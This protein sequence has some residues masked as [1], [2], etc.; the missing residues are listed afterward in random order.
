[1]EA[2]V[3]LCRPSNVGGGGGGGHYGVL[4]RS[5]RSGSQKGWNHKL[6]SNPSSVSLP[7][8]CSQRILL[9]KCRSHL[10]LESTFWGCEHMSLLVHERGV[11]KETWAC[12]SSSS[13]SSSSLQSTISSSSPSS[14][15]SSS[16]SSSTSSSTSSTSTSSLFSSL[17][18]RTMKG[19]RNRTVMAVNGRMTTGRRRNGR[20]MAAA[21]AVSTGLTTVRCGRKRKLREGFGN[22]E[23]CLQGQFFLLMSL[24][25][26][27]GTRKHLHPSRGDLQVCAASRAK[28]TGVQRSKARRKHLFGA[29][30]EDSKAKEE[31]KPQLTNLQRKIKKKM[32]LEGL[33]PRRALKLITSIRNVVT[34]RL[35][36][37]YETLDR[38]AAWD[39][40]FPLSHTK[41]AITILR[42]EEDWE[43]VLQVSE[44]MVAKGYGK[45]LNTYLLMLMAYDKLSRVEDAEK[46]FETIREENPKNVSRMIWCTMLSIFLRRGRYDKMEKLWEL[47]MTRS[48]AGKLPAYAVG[49]PLAHLQETKNVKFWVRGSVFC[50]PDEVVLN[51]VVEGFVRAG[52]LK[53]AERVL[54]IWGQEGFEIRRGRRILKEAKDRRLERYE[55]KQLRKQGGNKDADS[56]GADGAADQGD[57]SPAGVD[58]KIEARKRALE[59]VKMVERLPNTKT[60]FYNA[61]NAWAEEPGQFSLSTIRRAI[62]ILRSER[63]WRKLVQ[64]IRWLM[65]TGRKMPSNSYN[66]L[67]LSYAKLGRVDDVGRLS[68]KMKT[69]GPARIGSSGVPKEEHDGADN[70]EAQ[71]GATVSDLEKA[72]VQTP[73]G[74]SLFVEKDSEGETKKGEAPMMQEL[75]SAETGG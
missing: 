56:E 44:W 48:V 24:T 9:Q 12:S 6:P 55:V 66:L 40:D 22:T 42:S 38:W 11:K 3:S 67:M 5:D 35:E 69:M 49:G 1:M 52:D 65:D 53:K 45:T 63:R 26:R 64:I 23:E 70:G 51:L 25:C 34:N 74:E 33:D 20:V 60:A 37:V 2:T 68:A 46:L 41:K 39:I 16:S 58:E 32:R 36:D 28:R 14:S 59:L 73:A 75:W 27:E 15:S 18:V 57:V 47:M 17:G 29:G 7:R 21:A 71:S 8:H 54:D 31:E 62:S 61:M 43:R 13:S 30:S 4:C 19:L 72:T 10:K 50:K